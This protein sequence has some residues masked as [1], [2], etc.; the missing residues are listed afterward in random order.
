MIREV[1]EH[2]PRPDPQWLAAAYAYAVRDHHSGPS[3]ATAPASP[4]SP[5]TSTRQGPVPEMADD[6]TYYPDVIRWLT[7]PPHDQAPTT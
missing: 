2:D 3:A 1:Y 7:R 4:A 5:A 6:S